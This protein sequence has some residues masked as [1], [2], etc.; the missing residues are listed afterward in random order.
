MG[1]VYLFLCFVFLLVWQDDNTEIKHT[2]SPVAIT[3]KQATAECPLTLHQ[4]QLRSRDVLAGEAVRRVRLGVGALGARGSR[5][6][7]LA[8]SAA[9]SCW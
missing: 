3:K 1:F 8:G 9:A 5:G 4:G 7:P 6:S 2:N